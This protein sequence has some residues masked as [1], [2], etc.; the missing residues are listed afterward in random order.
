MCSFTSQSRRTDLLITIPLILILDIL[1]PVTFQLKLISLLISLFKLIIYYKIMRKR[2]CKCV[3]FPYANVFVRVP[4]DIR[5][6]RKKRPSATNYLKYGN[7]RCVRNAF[8]WRDSRNWNSRVI[9]IVR[10]FAPS[11]LSATLPRA[12]AVL[13]IY[14]AVCKRFDANANGSCQLFF[15]PLPDS[16]DRIRTIGYTA[17]TSA[18]SMWWGDVSGGEGG[19]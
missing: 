14:I 11:T 15:F 8:W 13:T 2:V 17:S 4:N 6:C 10:V 5:V 1:I 7:L 16:S 19:N 9:G 3:M 18:R 12:F